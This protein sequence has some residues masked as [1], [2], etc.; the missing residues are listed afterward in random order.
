[1]SEETD[2]ALGVTQDA[3]RQQGAE[4]CGNQSSSGNRKHPALSAVSGLLRLAAVIVMVMGVGIGINFANPEYGNPNPVLFF[5]SAISGALA[6]VLIWAFADLL[7]VFMGIE[8][9]TR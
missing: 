7:R 6:A 4:T 5:I 8:Q 2:K 3:P 9:N 1:M